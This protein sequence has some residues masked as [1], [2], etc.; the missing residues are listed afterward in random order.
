MYIVGADIVVESLLQANNG[1]GMNCLRLWWFVTSILGFGIPCIIH[2]HARTL[3]IVTTKSLDM[4]S[5]FTVTKLCRQPLIH[6][7]A[8]Y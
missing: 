4:L 6:K 8:Y 2:F 5:L 1:R 3:F 7:H